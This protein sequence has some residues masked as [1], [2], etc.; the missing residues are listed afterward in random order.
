MKRCASVRRKDVSKYYI[1]MIINKENDWDHSVEGEAVEG[2]VVCVGREEV[3]QA[4]SEV[5][6]GKP[7]ELQ[8]HLCS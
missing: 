3:L 2:T 4:L 6:T 7:L 1:K 5:K 8:M